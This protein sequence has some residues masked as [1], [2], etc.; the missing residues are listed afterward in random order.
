VRKAEADY[1]V[2]RQSS[3]SKTPLHDSVCF[4]CQQLAAKYLKALL[5]EHG[6]PVPR[7]HNLDDLLSLLQPPYPAM[8]ALRRGLIFLTDFAVEYRYPGENA[9]KRQAQAAVRWAERMR[10]AGRTLLGIR[11]RQPQRKR[12]P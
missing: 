6:L 4:H 10:S 7:T 8:R 9:S 1:V 5:A 11:P 3:R 2:A 12:S